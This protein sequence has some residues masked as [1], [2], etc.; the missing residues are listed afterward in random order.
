MKIG[1]PCINH[2]LVCRSNRRFILRS[3][4]DERL[5]QT[6]AGNLVCLGEMLEFNL[7]HNLRF[8]RIGS[9]LVPF[10]SH[11]VCTFKWWKHFRKTFAD[12]GAFIRKNDFR[13]SMHPDQFTLL[14]AKD[15]AIVRRSI[16]E[17]AYHAR[18]LDLMEL[19][20]RAKI[21]IHVGGV[22][23]EKPA[24]MARF[25]RVYKKLP[26]AIKN[27]LVIENDDTCYS[28]ADC[29][30]IHAE[31]GIPVLVDN[32][33]HSLNGDGL[34]VG[35]ALEQVERTWRKADGIPMTDYSEQMPGG[36]VGRHAL[37]I[38]PAA[39]RRYLKA[40]A[41]IDFEI[42]LEIKDKEQSAIKAVAVA[43]G[44]PRFFVAAPNQATSAHK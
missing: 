26:A 21:Q 9:E 44:D 20:Q 28:V 41:P 11:P 19:D 35:K 8:L 34:A 14:N 32:L 23:G 6:V 36:R 37:S 7:E 13:I 3:Y 30:A 5:R 18:V 38:S 22:Y 17:L 29:L 10:A 25:V 42:M 15:P 43:S 24:S 31:T 2:F 1:Y 39:F 12:L 16:A 27:R 4:S 40:T 33:H